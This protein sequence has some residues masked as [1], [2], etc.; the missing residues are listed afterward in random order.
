LG[1]EHA[2]LMAC[3]YGGERIEARQQ[4]VAA[5][6]LVEFRTRGLRASQADQISRRRVEGDQIGL[7]QRRG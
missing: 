1:H 2:E 5:E 7:G 3:V 6:N 4:A